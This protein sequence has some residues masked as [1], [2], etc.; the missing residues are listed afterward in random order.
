MLKKI[1]VLQITL[2]LFYIM[3]FFLAGYFLIT[4]FYISM[5]FNFFILK[6]L[7]A[8]MFPDE[9]PEEKAF[10]ERIKDKLT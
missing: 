7:L 8:Y 1:E 10:W 4:M 5:A 6:G 2:L 9:M 3:G